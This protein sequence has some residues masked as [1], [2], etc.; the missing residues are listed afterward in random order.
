MNTWIPNDFK[1]YVS[2]NP[3]AL[4]FE[5]YLCGPHMGDGYKTLQTLDWVVETK[6]LGAHTEPAFYLTEEQAQRL[7]Q[8]LSERGAR[9][10][11]VSLAEGKLEATERHLQDLRILLKL[12]KP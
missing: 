12:R 10:P 4:A 3:A 11:N 5:V 1:F 9:P 8:Q 2:W 7:I 6:P